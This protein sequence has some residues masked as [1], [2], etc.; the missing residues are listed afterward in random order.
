[1][2]EKIFN[3]LEP[4]REKDHFKIFIV[5]LEKEDDPIL[6]ELGRLRTLSYS[7]IGQGPQEGELDIDEYD[8][9]YKH[10]I[11]W[12]DDLNEIVG[13][14]RISKSRDLIQENGRFMS[15]TS[16]NYTHT[17][18]FLESEE[19]LEIARSFI[20]PKYWS[21]N[22]LDHLWIGIGAYLLENPKLRYLYGAVTMGEVYSNKAATLIMQFYLKWYNSK[23]KLVS[24]KNPMNFDPKDLE[25][26]NSILTA[27]N[28]KKDELALRDALK[29][30]G[31]SIPVL[32]R[33]YFGIT[34][35]GGTVLFAVGKDP[36]YRSFSM[37]IR[38]D[39]QMLRDIYENRYLLK[40]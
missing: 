27:D 21:G 18:E 8:I 24:P 23:E 37:F 11:V 17:K 6:L 31:N 20:Q 5:T 2:L 29:E 30:M 35:H 3:K 36:A 40:K 4:I 32:L 25:L 26:A 12:D 38:M 10:L 33:K 7:K 14:Y 39:M 16:V 1:M 13:S 15:Y 19:Y 28:P 9:Y 22:F 34:E